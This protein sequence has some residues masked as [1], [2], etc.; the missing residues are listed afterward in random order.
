MATIPH[1]PTR[2][3]TKKSLHVFLSIFFYAKFYYFLAKTIYD[4]NGNFL[5][6]LMKKKFSFLSLKVFLAVTRKVRKC[7]KISVFH[8]ISRNISYLW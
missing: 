5:S 1:L 6:F 7:M 2:Y 3:R 8:Y 4:S